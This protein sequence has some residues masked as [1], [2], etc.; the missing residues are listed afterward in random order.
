MTPLKDWNTSS[1]TTMYCMF[2]NY[3][4]KSFE[5][6]RK[7]NVSKV[8]DF[9]NMFNQTK[10]TTVTTLSGLEEWDV[11]SAKVMNDMFF[12]G[13]KLEDVS[14]IENWDVTNVEN[15]NSMFSGS[16]VYPQFT[17]VNGTWK[18]GTFT[19]Q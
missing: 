14:A 6:F 8:E 7:W 3:N 16:K 2:Q 4:I 12:D 9:S 5:P 1:A 17:K 18:N 10:W 13:H 11:S 19:K 15:F